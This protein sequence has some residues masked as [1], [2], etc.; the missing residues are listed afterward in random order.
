MLDGLLATPLTS[1]PVQKLLPFPLRT[2]ARM[3]L[4]AATVLA[5]STIASNINMDSELCFEGF[6]SST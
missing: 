1:R 3:D 2:T 6:F 4:S 5:A